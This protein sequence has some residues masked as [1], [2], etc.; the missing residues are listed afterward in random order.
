MAENPS[1]VSSPWNPWAELRRRPHVTFS[2]ASELP[3]G[4][5]GGVYERRGR[6]SVIL[7]D[8]A[9]GRRER[10]VVLAHELIH[11]ERSST[12]RCEGMPGSWDPVI[13]RDEA[14]IDA[15]VAARLVPMHE[16]E[17]AAR[18][19]ED[20]GHVLSEAD[21]AEGWDVTEAIAR[22]AMEQLAEARWSRRNET[23]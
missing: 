11:D 4:T 14:R 23:A 9:L 12:C 7:I 6:R 5:G 10:R 17:R 13:A 20:L 19:A 16:L 22:M 8:R 1:F 3:A 2:L 15:E 21:V 18:T